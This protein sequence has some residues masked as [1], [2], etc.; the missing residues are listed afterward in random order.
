[1]VREMQRG[2]DGQLHPTATYLNGPRGPEYRRDD[3]TGQVKW[4]VYDGQG[5]VVGEMDPDGNYT[6]S[7]K[8]DV[9]GAVRGRNGTAT[10]HHG[11]VGS[12]GHLSEPNTGLIYMRARYYDPSLG[13]FINEDPVRDG[14]NWFA[15]C[16]NNPITGRDFSGKQT[17]MADGETQY[18]VNSAYVGFGALAGVMVVIGGYQATQNLAAEGLFIAESKRAT[19]L[20]TNQKENK[21]IEDEA[22]LRG[23]PT[24]DDKWRR[25]HDQLSKGGYSQQEIKDYLDDEKQLREEDGE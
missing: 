4:Y 21:W 7:T 16:D 1:M 10:S 5:S 14:L 2:T 15:Y 23:I 3:E 22:K 24:N 6:A 17:L 11:F 13:R 18:N 20:G 12:L 8:Y 19:K 25:I 9:Y